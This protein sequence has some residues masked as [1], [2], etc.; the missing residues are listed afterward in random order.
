MQPLDPPAGPAPSKQVFM[1]G[2]EKGQPAE[3]LK[4]KKKVF[5]KLRAD[6]KITEEC[7][8]QWKQTNCV[9]KPG[10]ISCKSLKGWN[11]S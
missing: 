4:P 8:A 6:F 3:E 5:E 2:Y 1:K 10:Y 7:T 11:I 9:T